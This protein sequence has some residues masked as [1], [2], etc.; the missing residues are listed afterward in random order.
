MSS[1]RKYRTEPPGSRASSFPAERNS[2]VPPQSKKALK[3]L[4]ANREQSRP[5][6]GRGDAEYREAGRWYDAKRPGLGIEF[7]DEV[8]SAVRRVLEF[9]RAGAPVP[10]ESHNREFPAL[11]F[12]DGGGLRGTRGRRASCAA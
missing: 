7:F 8:D 1:V 6:R 5:L 10:R 11:P 3:P 12:P 2:R 4:S 9:P